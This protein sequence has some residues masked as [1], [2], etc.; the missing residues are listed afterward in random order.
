MVEQETNLVRFFSA[1]AMDAWY[2]DVHGVLRRIISS[3]HGNFYGSTEFSA[4]EIDNIR[5]HAGNFLV[6]CLQSWPPAAVDHSPWLIFLQTV[7]NRC[8]DR[9]EPKKYALQVSFVNFCFTSLLRPSQQTI[10]S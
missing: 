2:K 10:V 8:P 5:S 7:C 6:M 4:K 1:N 3:I 9:A